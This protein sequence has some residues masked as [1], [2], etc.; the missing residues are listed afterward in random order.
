PTRCN[1]W[2]RIG[3]G[4]LDHCAKPRLADA[5]ARFRSSA[6]ERGNTPMT[7]FQSAGL[8]FSKYSPVAGTTQSPAMK[9]LNCGGAMVLRVRDRGKERESCHRSAA[10]VAGLRAR[11]PRRSAR[12]RVYAQCRD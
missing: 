4:V 9:F 2:P 5:M 10:A 1:T 8:R 3:A 12:S 11:D 6:P 7:S